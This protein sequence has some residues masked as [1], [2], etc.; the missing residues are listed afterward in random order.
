MKLYPAIKARMGRWEY[1]LVRMSMRELAGQ[2]K[3]A[4]EIYGTT[5]LSYAIQRR[6]VESRAKKEIASYLVKQQDRF[7]SSIVVAALGGKPRWHPVLIENDPQ[8]TF[9]REDD[10]LAESFGVLV[11]D[12][13]EEYYALDGQHRLAAIQSLVKGTAD[14]EPTKEFFDE[15]VGVLV[16]K[17]LEIETDDEF[18]IRYRRLFGHLNRYAKAMSKFDIIVMDED[19]PFAVITR[20]LVTDHQF[21]RSFGDQFASARVKMQSGKNITRR[22]APH[23]TTLETLYQLNVELLHS[24]HRRNVGWGE[25]RSEHKEY[26]RFRPSDDEIESLYMELGQ[27]WDA[28]IETLPILWEDPVR[29]REHDADPEIA[30][31]DKG[32]DCVLF[33]PIVQEMLTRLSRRLMDDEVV[34]RPHRE[35]GSA[36]Q[37][38]EMREALTPLSSI[39]WNAHSPPWRHILLVRNVSESTRAGLWKIAS[40][41]RKQRLRLVERILKWQIGLDRLSEEDIYGPTGIRA[42]WLDY[43]PKQ[44]P[45]Q[46]NHMWDQIESNVR[47]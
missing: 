28:L 46:V 14:Y 5:H 8:F 47:R 23:F 21:F 22:N 42:L 36:L 7:F 35:A 10:R 9:F 11:F 33:W 17:P 34:R 1:F 45:E 25:S 40:D 39:V 26:I 43:L 29:M 3:Y 31:G 37:L 2:V 38:N 18:K 41:D 32:E 20:R 13:T 44:S 24:R 12:G 30:N 19:D 6:L 4:D 16:V 15:E 27:C